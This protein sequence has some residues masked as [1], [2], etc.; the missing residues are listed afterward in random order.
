MGM[1]AASLVVG[2]LFFMQFYT[3]HGEEIV[4]PNLKGISF[5]Q[6]EQKLTDLGLTIEVIDTG[7]VKTLPADVILD[8]SIAPNQRVK[9]GRIVYIVIN[10]AHARAI[11]LPDI[12]DNCSLREA[13]ARLSAIGF[14]LNEHERINGDLDWVYAIKVNGRTVPAGTRIFA[15][16]KL[17]LVVGNGVVEEQFNGN[18]SLDY[19]YFFTPE[20][21]E[22][23]PTPTEEP[24]NTEEAEEEVPQE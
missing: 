8:Q 10:S 16:Q 4:V 15:D 3:H 21:E 13:I 22:A 18:D 1:V 7:Y 5:S 2:A 24:K 14:Q 12:A 23:A 11:A 17:T 20:P 9:P 19:L 6:A